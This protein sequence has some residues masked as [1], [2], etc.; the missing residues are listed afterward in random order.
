MKVF[1]EPRLLIFARESNMEESKGLVAAEKQVLFE[2]DNFTITTGLTLLLAA[3]YVFYV[4]YPNSSPAGSF[5]LFIQEHLLGIKDSS[6]KH[7][8]NI[9]F[10]Y[11]VRTY[12]YMLAYQCFCKHNVCIHFSFVHIYCMHVLFLH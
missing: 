7:S 9:T 4:K 1:P 3:Y 2:I 8:Q 12:T 6:I 5:L 11:H 10:I